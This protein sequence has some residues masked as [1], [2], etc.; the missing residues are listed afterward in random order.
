MIESILWVLFI[1]VCLVVSAVVLLQDSKGGGLGEA[2]GGTGQAAFGV[3]NRGIAKFTGYLCAALVLLAVSITKMRST[4]SVIDLGDGSAIPT[5]VDGAPVDAGD[6]NGAPA[7][8]ASGAPAGGDTST[9]EP[10]EKD[11]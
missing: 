1:L 11:G 4:E 6:A 9:P 5:S 8:D 2:F 7:G 10:E 3:D